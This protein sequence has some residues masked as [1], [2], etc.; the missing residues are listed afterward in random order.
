MSWACTEEKLCEDTGRKPSFANRKERPHQKSMLTALDVWPTELWENLF[1]LLKPPT[2]MLCH[3]T[4]SRL[5]HGHLPSACL[6]FP[7]D[8]S[9][10]VLPYSIL[11]QCPSHSLCWKS[12]PSP[13]LS[14]RDPHGTLSLLL[15]S[16]ALMSLDSDNLLWP[17][18]FKIWHVPFLV[19]HC[20]SLFYFS[21]QHLSPADIIDNQHI[22]FGVLSVSSHCFVSSMRARMIGC[23][24]F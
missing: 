24:V 13:H 17:P 11:F 10:S 16:F 6:I 21:S 7:S 3:S 19:A 1:L 9:P 12:S 8:S 23:F 5:L 2:L 20:I 14:P 22:Y 4:P 18:L 15:R